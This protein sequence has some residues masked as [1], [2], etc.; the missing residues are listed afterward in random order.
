MQFSPFLFSEEFVHSL[1]IIK[2]P[3]TPINIILR[4]QHLIPDCQL[5]SHFVGILPVSATNRV[6]PAEKP[7][8][9]PYF[10]SCPWSENQFSAISRMTGGPTAIPAGPITIGAYTEV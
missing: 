7:L 10:I 5:F 6:F 1:L 4:L 9:F 2:A 8:T 3:N